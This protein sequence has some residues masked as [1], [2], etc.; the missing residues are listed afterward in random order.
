MTYICFHG[1]SLEEENADAL[2]DVGEKD[3]TAHVDFTAVAEAAVAQ[4]LQLL[5]YA[6]QAQFFPRH[7]LH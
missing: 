1:K 5:G 7:R 6:G 3:I 4:G 2:Q